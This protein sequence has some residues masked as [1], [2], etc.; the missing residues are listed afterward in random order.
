MHSAAEGGD[1]MQQRWI[2][3]LVV[4]LALT[5]MFSAPTLSGAQETH[6]AM[7]TAIKEIP[8]CF[9]GGSGTLTAT[10]R[11]GDAAIDYQL[12]YD[13]LSG[14]VTQAHIHFGK[15]F[16][17][18]GIVVFLCSNLS[19]APPDVPANTPA[20]PLPSGI[21]TGTLDAS[22]VIARAA[23]QGINTGEF[24]KVVDAMRFRAGLTYANVHSSLCPGGEIRG[25]IK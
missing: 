14:T 17:Q 2:V 11:E 5:A 4:G 6:R 22:S 25:Q 10:I 23:A 15:R 12:S 19:P 16:E 21:V 7:L 9:S 24:A 3:V 13:G 20:C 18:G 8:T 1:M